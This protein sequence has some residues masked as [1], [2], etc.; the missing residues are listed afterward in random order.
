MQAIVRCHYVNL[1][2]FLTI[3][4]LLLCLLDVYTTFIENLRSTDSEFYFIASNFF[5]IYFTFSS[6][7]FYKTYR[8]HIAQVLEIVQKRIRCS[9]DKSENHS[10]VC[11]QEFHRSEKV[12]QNKG[13][14]INILFT[15]HERKPPQGSVSVSLLHAPRYY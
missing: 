1:L 12:S 8:P 10:Q 15:T 3:L 14:S 6:I 13:T 7:C 5:S 9:V 11:N 4:G 2:I